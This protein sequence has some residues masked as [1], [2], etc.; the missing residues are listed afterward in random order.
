MSQEAVIQSIAAVA[1]GFSD[2]AP[3][4]RFNL[5]FPIWRDDWTLDK[6]GKAAAIKRCTHIPQRVADLLNGMLTRQQTLFAIYPEGLHIPAVSTAPFATGLGSEHPVENGFAF[7]TPYGLPYLAG[8]GVKGVVRRAAEELALFPD[9]YAEEGKPVPTLLD[10]WWL[11][12]FE[13]AAG[14]WWPLTSK[15]Q[16]DLPE[17]TKDRRSQIR[18]RFRAHLATLSGRPD[19]PAWICRTLPP[20]RDRVR[21]LADPALFLSDLDDLRQKIHTRGALSFWDVFPK[22]PGNA[23]AVEIMTPHFSDYY[24]RKMSAAYPSGATPHDAGQPNPIPFLAVPAGSDFAFHAV[25]EPHYLPEALRPTWK[26]LLRGVFTHAFDWMGFG[27][28]TAVGYGAM[29]APD[30]P[31]EPK[32]QRWSEVTLMYAAG[33]GELS[34]TYQGQSARVGNPDARHLRESLPP[35][36]QQRLAKQKQLKGCCV[37][38]EKTGNAWKIVS[39]SAE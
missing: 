12:G 22:P 1:G 7:L 30:P 18:S 38:V 28:K 15:E 25:C 4:H 32:T 16:R 11:F 17:D 26:A 33:N 9:D 37:E 14:A 5:Y 29:V 2:A 8:S 24:Q 6:Q 3:G 13:G 31:P 20:G 10:V 21:Y 23:L 36:K 34:V 19:L 35:E 27:A 39:V